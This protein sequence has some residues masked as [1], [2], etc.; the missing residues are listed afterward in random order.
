MDQFLSP[1]FFDAAGC[2]MLAAASAL[3][4]RHASCPPV[5]AAA[6]GVLCGLLGPLLRATLAGQPAVLV[7][8]TSLYPASALGGGVFGAFLGR[9]LW[10]EGRFYALLDAAGLQLLACSGVLVVRNW[11]L[12]LSPLGI[13]LL[14]AVAAFAPGLLR[15]AALGDT[16]ALA[17]EPAYATAPLLGVLLTIGCLALRTPLLTALVAGWSV[18][19]LARA[20][21]L[22]Q[23][24]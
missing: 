15:D 22:R 3:R 2:A 17:D 24:T 12:S 7:L 5:G 9:F 8:D 14:A 23:Q 19:V 11:L 6:L 4:A 20:L 18:G 10:T 16:A 1:F 13:L 21:V